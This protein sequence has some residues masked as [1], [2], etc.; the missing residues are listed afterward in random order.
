MHAVHATRLSMIQ[1][2]LATATTLDAISPSSRPLRCLSTSSAQTIVA[3]FR[4]SLAFC[5]TCPTFR[6]MCP[7]SFLHKVRTVSTAK[8]L[9]LFCGGRGDVMCGE[10]GG[11]SRPVWDKP[12]EVLYI[13]CRSKNRADSH[14]RRILTNS[15]IDRFDL[16]GDG[17]E[18][19]IR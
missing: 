3:I 16:R 15:K 17:V 9:V 19:R 14:I 1:P 6:H 12:V 8:I 2:R 13:F 7:T 11:M 18:S 10:T 4:P 5:H